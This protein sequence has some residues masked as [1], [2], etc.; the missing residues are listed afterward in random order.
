MAEILCRMRVDIWKSDRPEVSWMFVSRRTK[1]RVLYEV[2]RAVKSRI[3]VEERGIPRRWLE[4]VDADPHRR[5]TPGVC[6]IWWCQDDREPIHGGVHYT[7][8][9]L[10]ILER[11]D[12]DMQRA[13]IQAN[14]LREELYRDGG[15]WMD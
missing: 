13:A 3:V 8:A 9:L 5:P 12:A 10:T 14:H 15:E 4:R 6:E 2:R 11:I 1:T 7:M